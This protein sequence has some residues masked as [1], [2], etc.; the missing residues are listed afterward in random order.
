LFNSAV[1]GKVLQYYA[2]HVSGGQFDLSPRYVNHVPLPN[3]SQLLAD[4]VGGEQIDRLAGLAE[5]QLLTD[6]PGYGDE[7]NSI[8]VGLYGPHIIA[9]L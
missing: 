4:E 8:V 1:F 3:F 6:I 2:P 9:A 7:I 5:K